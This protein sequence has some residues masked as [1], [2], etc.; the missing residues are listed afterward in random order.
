MQKLNC[1]DFLLLLP[2]KFDLMKCPQ[3]KYEVSYVKTL[4]ETCFQKKVVMILNC[5]EID[6]LPMNF[7]STKK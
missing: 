3:M 4:L 2:M 1:Y 7:Q 5:C 6:F